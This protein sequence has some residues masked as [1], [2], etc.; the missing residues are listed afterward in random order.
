MPELPEVET[1]VRGLRPALEGRTLESIV[2]DDPFLLQGCTAKELERRG[3]GA[4]VRSVGR[5]GKWVVLTL[6]EGEGLIVIQPRMTGGFRVGIPDRPMHVRL[7]FRLKRPGRTVWY[8]DTRRLGK[9]AWYPGSEEADRA[10]AK[11]HGPDALEIG[12]DDLAA[13]L[14]RTAR[15]IKPAL[16]DQKILAGV[17]NIYADESLFRAGLHP[18]R[19]ASGLSADEVGRLHEA[20]RATLNLAI[21]AEGS[22]F[23]QGY[24]TVLGREGGYL[25][26]HAVVYGRKG[27]PCRRCGGPVVKTKIAGLVGRP[28]YLC[29]RCQPASRRGRGPSGRTG[30]DRVS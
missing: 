19:R 26:Q 18:E 8:C 5:R 12:R 21:D 30:R 28:T 6:G 14:K 10:F 9:V 17:G 7:T 11:S 20:I 29:P 16:L 15:G 22:S 25:G 27:E 4:K 23:D 2:V 24:L 3:R 13:R 1:M